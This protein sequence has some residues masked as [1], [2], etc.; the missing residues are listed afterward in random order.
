MK[1]CD[2]CDRKLKGEFFQVIRDDAKVIFLCREDFL[3][4]GLELSPFAERYEELDG[5]Y[6]PRGTL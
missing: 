4:L 2:Q 6:W 3:E 5:I 1:R